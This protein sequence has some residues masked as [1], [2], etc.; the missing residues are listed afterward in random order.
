VKQ[1]LKYKLMNHSS[2]Q[3][4]LNGSRSTIVRWSKL[5]K[6]SHIYSINA[7]VNLDSEKKVIL[8]LFF[9]FLFFFF[10]FFFWIE[11]NLCKIDIQIEIQINWSEIF[12]IP[13]TQDTIQQN[14]IWIRF[15]ELD[16]KL[17]GI[18]SVES[19]L[20]DQVIKE[21]KPAKKRFAESYLA[22]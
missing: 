6:T 22:R 20:P 4:I 3:D 11:I 18:L 5:Y 14:K 2:I 10:L 15:G 19:E 13:Q 7:I 21:K 1:E 16:S 17:F 12:N 9:S 8:I